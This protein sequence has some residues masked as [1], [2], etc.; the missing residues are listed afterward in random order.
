MA[1]WPTAIVEVVDKWRVMRTAVKLSDAN[2]SNPEQ[3]LSR[4]VLAS[5]PQMMLVRHVMRAGWKGT[6]HSHP[7]EQLVYVIKGRL[8]FMCGIEV[9]EISAGDSVIVPADAEHEASALEE[10]E[11]LDVFSPFREEYLPKE[12]HA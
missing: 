7:Q 2:V 8:R 6:R 12:T 9:T 4:Q 5:S 3:G 1:V 11:V 10:S